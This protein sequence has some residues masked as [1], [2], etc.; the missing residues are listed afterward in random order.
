MSLGLALRS[1]DP[2]VYPKAELRLHLLVELE[3]AYRVFFR[4]L[5]DLIVPPNE[6]PLFLSSRPVLFPRPF[7]IR[8]GVSWSVVLESI[9]WHLA[10]VPLLLTLW[11]WSS[12]WERQR[13]PL[14]PATTALSYAQLTYYSPTESFPARGASQGRGLPPDDAAMP[15][16]PVIHV[17]EERRQPVTT[18]PTVKV[19]GA[20]PSRMTSLKQETPAMPLLAGGVRLGRGITLPTT[21]VAPAPA[22]QGSIRAPGSGDIDIGLS[23]VVPPTPRLPMHA[24]R[25][26]R[27]MANGTLGGPGAAIVAPPPTISSRALL[28]GGAGN[29]AIGVDIVPPPPSVGHAPILAGGAGHSPTSAGVQVVPPPP[30]VSGPVLLNGGTGNSVI[31]VD[32]VS[33]PPSVGHASSLAVGGGDSRIGAGMQ[34]VPPPP[35]ISGPGLLGDG[36]GNSVIGDVVPPPPSV[37][38]ASSLAVGGGGDSRTG[39]GVQVVPPPPSIPRSQ[40]LGGSRGGNSPAGMGVQGLPAPGMGNRGEGT[41]VG[42]ANA[43]SGTGSQ[44]SSG[45]GQRAGTRTGNGGSMSTSAGTETVAGLASDPAAGN[46]APHGQQPTPILRA[47]IPP[48][49]EVVDDPGGTTRV[50]LLRV[51]QLALTLPRTSYFSNYEAFVAERSVNNHATQLIKLVYIF[52]P[53][54]RGLTEYEVNNSKTLRL[55]VTRDPSCDESLLSMTWPESEP[56][57]G[58]PQPVT[59]ESSKNKLPCYRTT[60]DDYRKAL[61]RAH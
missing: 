22:L 56:T 41:G 19:S 4:N 23:V 8:T 21:V 35:S 25:A 31:S 9:A 11:T 36:T 37:G 26:G 32:I 6:P 47:T 10:A 5:A 3:P 13:Y 51:I 50:L 38:Y 40:V 17:T 58:Q 29:S 49:A 61:K 45:S 15:R 39:A 7:Y 44:G 30:S 18:P 34:V 54:Q 52:L 55:R 53:Y 12:G 48:P 42:G 60:A 43:L 33:P 16:Q 2:A 57:H 1:A 59:S 24:Q 27:G 28:N 20:A 46:T 14:Q